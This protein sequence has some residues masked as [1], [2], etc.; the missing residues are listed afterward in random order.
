MK[1]GELL[2]SSVNQKASSASEDA[3][4]FPAIAEGPARDWA[5]D[6][7]GTGKHL[8]FDGGWPALPALGKQP[9]HTLLS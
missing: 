8:K 1:V 5:P 6:G 2:L 7:C 3:Y 9:A 4:F